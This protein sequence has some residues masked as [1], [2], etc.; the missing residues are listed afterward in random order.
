MVG[1]AS[2]WEGTSYT[3]G[4]K[5]QENG[6]NWH[7]RYFYSENSEINSQK[8]EIEPEDTGKR[9]AYKHSDILTRMG[10]PV[11]CQ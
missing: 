10:L 8:H 2:L 4:S 6:F 7:E 9:L 5:C 11:L 3:T 1:K